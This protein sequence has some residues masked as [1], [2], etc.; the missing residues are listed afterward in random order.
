MQ[1]PN[2]FILNS[3]NSTTPAPLQG[4]KKIDLTTPAS[5]SVRAFETVNFKE[6]V[7]FDEPFDAIESIISCDEFPDANTFDNYYIEFGS[8]DL[9]AS[10]DVSGNAVSLY[11]TF[12]NMWDATFTGERHFHAIV[13]PVKSPY[14]QS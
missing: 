4:A 12:T 10:I 1:Y 9:M 3:D 11:V 13:I 5:V 14:N 2:K 6:T 8:T 7:Y